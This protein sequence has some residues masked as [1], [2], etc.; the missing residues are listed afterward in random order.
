MQFKT[1]ISSCCWEVPLRDT[2]DGCFEL[3]HFCIFDN[4]AAEEI[5][6]LSR[7]C[8]V[9]VF[10]HSSIYARNIRRR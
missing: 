10:P 5:N 7:V 2:C 9:P 1:M 3:S 6:R 4:Q 8:F